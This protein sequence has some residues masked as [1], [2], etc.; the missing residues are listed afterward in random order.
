[1]N[2]DYGAGEWSIPIDLAREAAFRLGRFEVQPSLCVLRL[3]GSVE[4]VEPRVM[5]VL[6]ALSQRGGAVVS[7]DELIQRC[8]AGLAVGDDAINRCIGKLRKLADF[9]SGASFR[10]ETVPRVGYRLVEFEQSQ[11]EPTDQ[12]VFEGLAAAANAA[13]DGG[14]ELRRYLL[15]GLPVAF[16]VVAGAI[17]ALWP[18]RN[19][20]ATATIPGASP[21]IAQ[22][23]AVSDLPTGAVFKDCADGCPEMVIVPPGYFAMGSPRSQSDDPRL[24]RPGVLD[25]ETP[26]HEVLIGRRFAVARYDV[27]RAEFAR[28]AAATNRP[29]DPSCYTLT[30]TGLFVETIGANWQHPGFEQSGRDPVVCMSLRDADDYAAWLAR[31][32]S[33]PYRLLSEAEWEYAAR[34]SSNA[35]KPAQPSGPCAVLN[36]ADADYHRRFPGDEYADADCHD[37]YSAT[38]PVGHFPAN[39]FGLFDMQGNVAQWTA[40]CY[41]ASY[42]GAPVDGSAWVS[43]DCIRRI[44]RGG[45]WAADSR[46]IRFTLR[47]Q[48]DP[49]SRYSANGFRVARAM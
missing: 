22:G 15:W 45:H 20:V 18:A 33:K 9:D 6:V 46:D 12:P 14:F 34:A 4:A 1:M 5:Q 43:S 19:Q 42:D 7:R 30:H 29:P 16:L 35:A 41:H 13:T 47:G 27:T 49:S 25:D 40:D 17:Y 39:A 26:Q 28:F 37:G 3:D 10:V 11:A 44:V 21:R 2:R 23:G 38:S 32:T 24:R 48:G 8:W 36:G 31:R